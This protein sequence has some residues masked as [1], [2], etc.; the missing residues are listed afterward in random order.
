MKKII[1][2][3]LCISVALYATQAFGI[4]NL[5]IYQ[6]ERGSVLLIDS[7]VKKTLMIAG[8]ADPRGAATAGDC[9][10]KTILSLNKLPN[11]YEG[12]LEPI[13]N[14]L[15]NI[16]SK[17]VAGKGVGIYLYANKLR[18][19]GVDTEGI[20]ADGIDFSGEY[21]EISERNAKYKS[22]F[23]YFMR[24]SS[25]NAVFLKKHGDTASAIRELK[26]ILEWCEKERITFCHGEIV[27]VIERN[28]LKLNR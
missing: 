25:Q 24:L 9:F 23:L 1:K 2:Y 8:G 3:A 28:Y 16:T 17:D 19:G 4:D 13:N 6:G 22:I 18:V 14:D 12:N 5:K 26:P 11:Y 15:I 21:R 10:I 7:D 27:D 20:C